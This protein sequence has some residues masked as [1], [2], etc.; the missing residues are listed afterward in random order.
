MSFEK[1]PMDLSALG[2]A[3]GREAF[4]GGKDHGAAD[5][6]LPLLER[7]RSPE[8]S[9]NPP[10]RRDWRAEVFFSLGVEGSRTIGKRVFGLGVGKCLPAVGVSPR[11]R[12]TV[13][14]NR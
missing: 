13:A 12:Q 11:S 14:E 6:T 4:V 7:R 8:L 10:A 2:L 5:V 9:K 1:A 3:V